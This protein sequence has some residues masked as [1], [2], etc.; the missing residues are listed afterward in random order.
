MGPGIWAIASEEILEIGLDF[1]SPMDAQD[2]APSNGRVQLDVITRAAP[3]V[4][5]AAE[6][7]FS[8]ERAISGNLEV[9]ERQG[10]EAALGEMRIEIDDGEDEIGAVFRFLAIAD[11]LW[12]IRRVEL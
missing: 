8:L 4:T 10:D 2:V 3:H 12:V 6:Q 5:L 11:D 7:V 1:H 9:I